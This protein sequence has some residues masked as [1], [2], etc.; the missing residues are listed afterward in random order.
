MFGKLD[1]K[2]S[3]G[4]TFY[5]YIVNLDLELTYEDLILR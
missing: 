5:M 1:E 4:T 3:S 2:S